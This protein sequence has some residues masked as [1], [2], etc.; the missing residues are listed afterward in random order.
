MLIHKNLIKNEDLKNV[1]T[2]QTVLGKMQER[3]LTQDAPSLFQPS[4]NMGFGQGV[5]EISTFNEALC[6]FNL[7]SLSAIENLI[8]DESKLSHLKNNFIE[9]FNPSIN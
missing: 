7:S 2:A 5:N 9:S 4:Q 6:A 1:P 3:S 8:A